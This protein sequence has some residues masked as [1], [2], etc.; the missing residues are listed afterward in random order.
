MYL[1]YSSVRP[2]N[3]L[4]SF[5]LPCSCKG[6]HICPHVT[7]QDVL[8]VLCRRQEALRPGLPP[9]PTVFEAVNRLSL[10]LPTYIRLESSEGFR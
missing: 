8:L 9:M 7:P 6:P 1:E 4:D 2:S 5:P 10:S 3:C